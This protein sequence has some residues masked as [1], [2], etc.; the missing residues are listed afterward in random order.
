[1]GFVVNATARQAICAGKGSFSFR[2]KL[3]SSMRG[4]EKNSGGKA[5]DWLPAVSRVALGLLLSVFVAGAGRAENIYRSVGYGNTA[6]LCEG[7]TSVINLEISGSAEFS[8]D[9]PLNIGVGDC[10]IYDS[11]AD[12][13]QDA[14]AFICGRENARNY[15]VCD[16]DG[17]DPAQT[18]AGGTQYWRIH[19]AYISLTDAAQGRENP[20][21]DDFIGRDFDN[22]SSNHVLATPWNIA[23]YAD[24]PN[25]NTANFSGWTTNQQKYLKLFTPCNTGVPGEVGVSQRHEGA[26]N[27]NAFLITV[28][29]N[30][31]GLLLPTYSQVEGLQF[32]SN[33]NSNGTVCA[34]YGGFSVV[35][36]SRISKCIFKGP[37][38]AASDA[39][40]GIVFSVSAVGKAEI[41]NNVFYDYKT[42]AEGAAAIRSVATGGGFTIRCYNNTIV[43]C[44]RG[45]DVQGVY[46]YAKNCIVLDCEDGGGFVGV[47]ET[48]SANNLS[49]DTVLPP[50]TDSRNGTAQFVDAAGGD[51]HLAATDVNA[52]NQGTDPSDSELVFSDDIDGQ[53]RSYAAWDIGA[54]EM[55]M[56][57]THTATVTPT[58]SPTATHTPTLTPTPVAGAPDPAADIAY[59]NP[60]RGRTVTF[61]CR[62]E[63]G[64]RID[65]RVFTALYRPVWQT[66]VDGVPGRINRVE[67]NVGD[68]PPGIYLYQI[69]T[70]NRKSSF[71][72]LAVVK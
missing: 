64:E 3:N 9:L 68:V 56:Q 61:T 59:P 39:L 23:C 6:P 10:I 72:K 5:P 70:G 7:I 43:N 54:D 46:A 28:P 49:N 47:S 12:H 44:E 14:V 25:T 30:N 11:G 33:V 52:C 21:M 20:G 51:F 57:P 63:P 27:N 15:S 32:Q 34:V 45:I 4:L 16:A 8:A 58:I 48:G 26:W 37:G 35:S 18:A 71:K 60:V 42:I 40:R 13:V 31:H 24:A 65:I 41:W 1:M 2:Q 67:W 36:D 19:R 38:E 55:A 17:E 22:W 69:R 53:P 50:G 66:A 62:P 29:A